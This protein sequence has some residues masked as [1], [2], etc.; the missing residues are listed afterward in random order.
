M[1]VSTIL[2]SSLLSSFT[3]SSRL[4]FITRS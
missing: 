1:E 3:C 4:K 2:P